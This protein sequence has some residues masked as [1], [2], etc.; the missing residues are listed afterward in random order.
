MKPGRHCRVGWL[1]GLFW[2]QRCDRLLREIYHVPA[3]V[4]K[5]RRAVVCP[6][7]RRRS[8]GPNLIQLTLCSR[9][10]WDAIMAVC[11]HLSHPMEHAWG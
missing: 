6:A 8:P 4:V 10:L 3:A 2:W 1:P 7:W 5:G 11:S 9:S